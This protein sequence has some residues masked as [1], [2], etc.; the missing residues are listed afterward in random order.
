MNISFTLFQLQEI[1]SG[2]DSYNKRLDEIESLL[3]NK[4]T[5][6]ICEKKLEIAEGELKS[7]SKDVNSVNDEIQQ[8]SIKISQSESTLYSGSVKNPKE[9]ED[10]QLEIASLKKV[11]VTLEDKLL[12]FLIVQ[13]ETENKA[14]AIKEELNSTKSEFATQSSRLQAEKD[15]ILQNRSGLAKKRETLIPQISSDFLHRYDNLRKN[16]RG[17][18][19]TNIKDD[20]C[21]A[22]GAVLTASQKQD[23]RSASSIFICST[24]GRIIYG[25]S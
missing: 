24:C 23:A 3:T 7:A 22:C 13:E 1:D 25:S 10:F 15:T 6:A 21:G 16:K 17:I 20:S 19:V 8:K 11:I 14:K 12:D 2:L 18:A 5:I 9:L 4:E